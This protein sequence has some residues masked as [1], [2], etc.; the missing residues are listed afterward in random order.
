EELRPTAEIRLKRGLVL[1]ELIKAEGLQIDEAAIDQRIDEM[2]ERYGV[3]ADDARK[4]LSTEENRDA[5]RLDLLSQAGVDR[6][7]AIAKGEVSN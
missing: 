6:A 7:A 2:V 1:S 5:L 3:R 4:S